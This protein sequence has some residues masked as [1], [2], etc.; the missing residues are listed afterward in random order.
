MFFIFGWNHSKAENV[1][2]VNRH[3][4]SNCHNSEFWQLDKIS[5][6]F[7]LFFIPIFP[8]S[9]DYWYHCPVCNYGLQLKKSDYENYKEIAEINNLFLDK[10]INEIDRD[11]RL[12]LIYSKIDTQNE[13]QEQKYIEES[14]DFESVVKSKSDS[15]LDDILNSDGSSYNPAFMLAAKF[16][17]DRRSNH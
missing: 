5:R 8:H 1:G 15:E 9:T 16:E 13:I 7:T 2:V 10:K 4:C 11:N 6:Y 3:E 17:K 12:K 14:K